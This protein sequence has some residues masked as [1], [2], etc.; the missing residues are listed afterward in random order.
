MIPVVLGPPPT[1]FDGKVKKRGQAHLKR[2]PDRS[3][4]QLTDYWNWEP[5]RLR[6]K[7]VFQE[8]C[9][10]LGLCTLDGQ[11][12]HFIAKAVDRDRA[13][14]WDNFRWA[15]SRVNLLKG[16]R[17]FLD[18]C[19]ARDDWLSINP[20]SLEFTVGAALPYPLWPAAENTIAVLNEIELLTARKSYVQPFC[21][22]NDWN[23]P[24]LDVAFPLLARAIRALPAPPSPS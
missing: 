23:L 3:P 8:R 14:D 18:P 11:V 22:E 24:A 6:L 13:Y 15:N 9:G 4:S 5:C 19:S 21:L 16:R 20:A 1:G 2:Y 17:A 7:E 10:Y 12:D